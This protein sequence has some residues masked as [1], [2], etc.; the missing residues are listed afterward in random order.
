MH[1]RSI[2][3]VKRILCIKKTINTSETDYILWVRVWVLV[4]NATFNNI[5]VI[6]FTYN[7]NQHQTYAR[8]KFFNAKERD[9]V[10]Y[11][12]CQSHR[13][14]KDRKAVNTKP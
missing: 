8:E 11:A 14:V 5:S 6:S 10:H 12:L 13:R 1:K 9:I 7:E 4:F 3:F 2:K